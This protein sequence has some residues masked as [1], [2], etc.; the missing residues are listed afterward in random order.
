MIADCLFKR[1]ILD[2]T[3]DGYSGLFLHDGQIGFGLTH[4]RSDIGARID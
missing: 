1:I 4:T 2:E 3:K